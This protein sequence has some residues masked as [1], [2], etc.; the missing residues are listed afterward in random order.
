MNVC[1]PIAEDRGLE[2]PVAGHFG[3]TP[4]FMIVDTASGACRAIVNGNRH[5]G[6]GPCNPLVSLVGEPLDCVVVGAIGPGALDKLRALGIPVRASGHTTVAEVL[7]ALKAD[8]LPVVDVAGPCANHAH[9]H[10]H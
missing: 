5:H 7:E 9:D 2:S 1:I 6:P 3:S 10:G 8:A 4:F